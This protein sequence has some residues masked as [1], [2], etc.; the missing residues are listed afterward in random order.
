N[1]CPHN[2]RPT[3]WVRLPSAKANAPQPP[4][5]SNKP[6][7]VVGKSVKRPRHS[8]R[9]CNRLRLSFQVIQ[10]PV[11]PDRKMKSSAGFSA[12]LPLKAHQLPLLT[13]QIVFSPVTIRDSLAQ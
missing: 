1:A 12:G 4:L 5:T 8:W 13:K 9:S 10:L 7:K 11:T 3:T 2:S 6:P